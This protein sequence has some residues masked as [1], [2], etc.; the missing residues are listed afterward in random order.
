MTVARSRVCSY[1]RASSASL[2]CVASLL[3]VCLLAAQPARGANPGDPAWGCY[4]PEP[5]HPTEAEQAAFFDKVIGPAK[6][7]EIRHGVP[8]AGIVAMSMLES[9]YGFT[10]TAKF[11]NN[12][13]GWKASDSDPAGFVL[14]CQP[15]SDPGNHYVRF[16]DWAAAIE[17]VSGRLGIRGKTGR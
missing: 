9:G 17:T 10:R 8:A 11:A 12:L 13:F 3:A 14:I 2:G 5:G 4:D 7:A 16:A 6:A 1:G 15:P